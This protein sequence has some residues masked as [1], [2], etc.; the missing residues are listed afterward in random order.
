MAATKSRKG[1]APRAVM[2][3]E[4]GQ[5]FPS[6]TKA[7]EFIGTHRNNIHNSMRLGCRAGGYHWCYAD[8]DINFNAG[9]SD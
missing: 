5:R 1:R 9:E 6:V 7:G 8:D 4:T 3:V 2:I